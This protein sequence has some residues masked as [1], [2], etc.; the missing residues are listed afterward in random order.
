[1]ILTLPL[2]IRVGLTLRDPIGDRGVMALA[3]ALQTNTHLRTL[4][5]NDQVVSKLG[6]QALDM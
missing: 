2:G 3:V 5:L 6:A 1:M 4:N